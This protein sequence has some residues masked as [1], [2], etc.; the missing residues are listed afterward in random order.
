MENPYEI[1]KTT[2]VR[3]RKIKWVLGNPGTGKLPTTVVEWA[4]AEA[5]RGEYDFSV[6][7]AALAE[8]KRCGKVVALRVCAKEIPAWA[9]ECPNQRALCYA[10]FIREL[11]SRY[12]TNPLLYTV[13]VTLPECECV[14]SEPNLHT[15]VDA[16]LSFNFTYKLISIKCGRVAKYLSDTDMRGV[17]LVLDARDGDWEYFGEQLAKLNFQDIWEYSPIRLIAKDVDE[18]LQAEATRWHVSII[19]VTGE[20]DDVWAENLGYRLE[21]RRITHP[22]TISTGGA[23]PLRF[24]MTNVGTAPC[25]DDVRLYTRLTRPDIDDECTIEHDFNCM[26][27]IPGDAIFN[28]I[29]TVDP[30]PT[31]HYTLEFGF[32]NADSETPVILGVENRLSDGF[33]F[34]S[35]IDLDDTERP[36]MYD[37]FDVVYPDGYYPLEDPKIPV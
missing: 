18:K 23:L 14:I 8:A 37:A 13:D 36:E 17:G 35:E 30:L 3:P 2:K 21:I 28:E 19:D 24:W 26:G 22:A 33:Y 7:D 11:S 6:L 10:C 4:K 12:D 27:W 29:V 31:G 15:V 9:G 25:Y 34:F 1:Y 32:F 20:V 16:F 5:N